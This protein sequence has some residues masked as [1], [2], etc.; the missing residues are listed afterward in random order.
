MPDEQWRGIVGEIL[1]DVL[2]PKVKEYV[3][4]EIK[5]AVLRYR[6]QVDTQIDERL[7]DLAGMGRLRLAFD[8][9]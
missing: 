7:D 3:D 2:L 4:Q 9:D 6:I 1:V 5:N 8:R